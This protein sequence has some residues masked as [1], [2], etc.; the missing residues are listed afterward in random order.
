MAQQSGQRMAIL[1]ICAF[2]ILGLVALLMVNE[3]RGVKAAKKL[4][5]SYS[6]IVP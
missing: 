4:H 3:K 2:L 6:H 5:M 1:A